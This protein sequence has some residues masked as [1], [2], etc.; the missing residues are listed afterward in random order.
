MTC[1]EEEITVLRKINK[2]LRTVN[3]GLRLQLQKSHEYADSLF[4]SLCGTYEDFESEEGGLP[5]PDI[6]TATPGQES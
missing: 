5:D 6:V 3:K 4:L 2:T 1:D